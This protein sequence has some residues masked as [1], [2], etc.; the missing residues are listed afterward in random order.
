MEIPNFYEYDYKKLIIIPL[1]LLLPSLYFAF[2]VQPGLEFKG[3]VLLTL[4]LDQPITEA[5]LNSELAN[6]GFHDFKVRAYTLDKT[7]IAEIELAHT[8]DM[9]QLESL[10]RE[11]LDTYDEYAKK[12]YQLVVLKNSN[13]TSS[14]ANVKSLSAEVDQLSAKLEDLRSQF[15]NVVYQITGKHY[16]LANDKDSIQSAYTDAINAYRS[17]LLSKIRSVVSFNNYS[18]KLVSPSLSELFVSKIEHIMIAAGIMSALVVFLMFKDAVPSLAVLTGATS[19]V[20]FAL[21]FM[22][23]AGIPLTLATIASVLMLVGY[24]LDT[25]ILITVRILKRGLK[26]PRKSAFEAFKT[27]FTMS[28]TSILAFASL[29]LVGIYTNIEIYQQI[30]QVVLAGLIGDIIATWLLNAVIMLYHVEGVKS[31]GQK[32]VA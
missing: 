28:F 12:Q 16:Q 17:N 8:D 21:G 2:Q 20:I 13:S 25:D 22:G 1:L 19:D 31:E 27:G 26:N 15:G 11:Y 30:S 14:Q 5:Q 18:F 6:A 24:S 29:Y 32:F 4:E 3:G 23:L 7:P 9:N 10:Y